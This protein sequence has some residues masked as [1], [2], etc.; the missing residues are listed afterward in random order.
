MSRTEGYAISGE[1]LGDRF[2]R[3]LY[4]NPSTGKVRVKR[5]TASV[6]RQVFERERQLE[7]TPSH[8]ESGTVELF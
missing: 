1:D 2:A 5:L 7:V 8:V 6:N 4:Y 3:K